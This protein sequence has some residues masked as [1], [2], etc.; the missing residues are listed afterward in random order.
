VSA[1]NANQAG[2]NLIKGFSEIISLPISM[3]VAGIVLLFTLIIAIIDIQRR[4][5]ASAISAGLNWQ[6]FIY[7]TIF[8]IGNYFSS[9][10]VIVP[11]RD[12]IQDANIIGLAMISSFS[13]VFAFKGVIT[14]LDITF[15]KNGILTIETWIEHALFNAVE[16]TTS[17][18]IDKREKKLYAILS[19]LSED[20]LNT[21]ITTYISTNDVRRL[22]KEALASSSD[23]RLYKIF[24]LIN[25]P[26]EITNKI[27]NQIKK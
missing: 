26:S 19:P 16:K 24:A 23:A 10:F 1:E 18:D 14:N 6:C 17:K 5:K 11:F 7:A 12:D 20:I 27:I 3:Y 9:I 25:Q 4:S 15:Y 21:Y 22:E 13:G 8:W 2:N